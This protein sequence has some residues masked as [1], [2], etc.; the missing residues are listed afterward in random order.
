MYLELPLSQDH[1]FDFVAIGGGLAGLCTAVAAARGGVKTA[2]VQ[3]RPVLG[4][5]AS[6]EVRVVPF[7]SA[8]FNTWARET[9]L[10]EEITLEDRAGNHF[11]FFE[12]GMINRN[13]DLLLYE[14][15]RREP[16]LTLFLNTSI[17]AV[18]T[19]PAGSEF[20][21]QVTAMRGLQLASEHVIRFSARQFADCTGDGTVG[22]LAGADWR[23]GREARS[24]FGENMAPLVADDV[25][26]GATITMRAVDIGQPVPYTPPSWVQVYRNE[27]EI[28]PHRKIA[29]IR[30]PMYG[31]YW[32][33]EVGYP[34]YHQINQT[35]ETRDELLSHV[36]GVWNYI[37]N[38]SPDR[39]VAATYALDWIGMI[40]GKRES[41]RLMGDVVVTE[42]DLHTDQGWPDRIFTAGWTIDL[43]IKG[44]ILNKEEPGELSYVDD[45]YNHYIRC[46]PFT[47]P[48]RAC[49]SRNIANLWMAG[50][51]LSASHVGMGAIRVQ[52][53]LANMGQAVGTAAAYAIRCGLSPRQASSPED[54]HIGRIQQQLLRDDMR[55]LNVRN[56]DPEDLALHA[57][58]SASSQAP[59]DFGVPDT[60]R[61]IPLDRPR[62]LIIPV[63]DPRIETISFYLK[64]A[65]PDPINITVKVEQLD[66]IWDRLPVPAL[67][68]V[69]L[70]IPANSSGW[71]TAVFGLN[72]TPNYPYRVSLSSAQSLFWALAEHH[73]TG[74]TAQFYVE[75]EAGC[76]PKNQHVEHLQPHEIHLPAFKRWIADKLVSFA[77]QINPTPQPYGPE[78]VVNG[79]SGPE[80]LPNLWVSDPE[81]VLPQSLILELSTPRMFNQVQVVFDT[82]LNLWYTRFGAL[83]RA[84]TC[85]R[86]W[87][88]FVESDDEWKLVY[89]EHD[90]YQRVCR[91]SLEP[92]TAQRLKLVIVS[93]NKGMTI[94][95]AQSTVKG[96][97]HPTQG[98]QPIHDIA[99]KTHGDT[100]RVY[101]VRVYNV[102]SDG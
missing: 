4:G 102:E 97:G 56:E 20:S 22:F 25:T 2:L 7:G 74:T 1:T 81:Q 83:W 45:H 46:V 40:P 17:Y 42:A 65:N 6:S 72:V 67:K 63:T 31:G 12:H 86:H 69:I 48:L 15:T 19:E 3:D 14:F 91:A 34:P 29:H 16:N 55:I 62:G 70:M 96:A 23:I 52:T 59:L 30:R 87:Q 11:D 35:P 39:Q 90:N 89:E 82:N 44:G 37:K 80:D 79:C 51:N 50:R 68:E 28:G 75:A 64:N 95:S 66:R 54:L 98:L 76:E 100:A 94:R 32:W 49:Y 99:M 9:G 38:Y 84:P 24:E 21:C 88:L 92:V 85:A 73:P 41:R 26:M 36:L 53:I 93:T 60:E 78:N 33:L 77:I 101:E 27:E 47:V 61:F 58:V 5:N 71:F 13:F 57:T 8:N 10:I 43:H 18:E